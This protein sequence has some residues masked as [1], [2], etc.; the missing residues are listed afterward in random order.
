MR[1]R[2]CRWHLSPASRLVPRKAERGAH[3]RLVPRRPQ[4]CGGS[5]A[6]LL[7]G[8]VLHGVATRGPASDSP[9]PRRGLPLHKL[10]LDAAA[11]R[12]PPG[13][14]AVG[15]C[16]CLASVFNSQHLGR[17]PQGGQS[18]VYFSALFSLPSSMGGETQRTPRGHTWPAG[19]G[20][21]SAQ[22]LEG[23]EAPAQARPPPSWPW[24]EDHCRGLPP[25]RCPLPARTQLGEMNRENCHLRAP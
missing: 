22:L 18:R 25:P 14:P 19:S 23:L 12:G 13:L 5:P 7:R 10:D 20:G 3:A 24:R 17:G 21:S 2:H 6:L 9:T 1:P 11:W 8:R 15:S 16:L 4:R